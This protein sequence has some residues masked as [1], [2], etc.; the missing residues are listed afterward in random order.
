[1]SPRFGIWEGWNRRKISNSLKSEN[2]IDWIAQNIVLQMLKASGLESLSKR[3]AR[4]I[5]AR[6]FEGNFSWWPAAKPRPGYNC[7]L[8]M[9]VTVGTW[10][11]ESEMS[12]SL[13]L[14]SE[15]PRETQKF[16]LSQ[17]W[18]YLGFGEHNDENPGN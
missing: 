3:T 13:Y 14:R 9:L 10:K 1:L 12:Q 15:D 17:S 7:A 11:S 5:A 8:C 4:T 6:F 18:P 16:W 2:F